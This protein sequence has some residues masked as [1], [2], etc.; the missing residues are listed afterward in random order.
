MLFILFTV[1][2]LNKKSDPIYLTMCFFLLCA[3]SAVQIEQGDRWIPYSYALLS[4]LGL[5]ISSFWYWPLGEPNPIQLHTMLL[6]GNRESL[7]MAFGQV[8]LLV[9]YGVFLVRIYRS[10]R[11][12]IEPQY[13]QPQPN[14]LSVF[15]GPLE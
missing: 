2:S 12:P 9:T 8:L 11:S 3:Y 14:E 7:M 10:F 13:A 1:L 4:F 5:P 6:A 15:S